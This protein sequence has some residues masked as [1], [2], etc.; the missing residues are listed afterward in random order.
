MVD[1]RQCLEDNMYEILDLIHDFVLVIDHNGNLLYTNSAYERIIGLTREYVRENILGRHINT[2]IYDRQLQ[3][4]ILSGGKLQNFRYVI[5]KAGIEVAGSVLPIY[6]DGCFRGAVV[7][8]SMTQIGE[9]FESLVESRARYRKDQIRFKPKDMLPECFQKL[10]GNNITFVKTLV[11]ASAAAATNSTILLEGESGVGKELLARAIHEASARRD[12]PFITINCAAIPESLL[13]S[14]LFGYETGAFTGASRKGKPGRFELASGGTLF[15]DEV[16]DLSLTMQAKILRALQFH[17]IERVGGT[18]KI[19]VDVR[20]ISATNKNLTQLT[21]KG[22]FREDLYYRLNVIPITLPPLAE[23]K[24]DIYLLAD[25]FLTGLCREYRYG[26]MRFA[27]DVIM[28]FHA[29]HW[30]GNVRE[31]SNVIEH[32]FV[33]AASESGSLITARHL[34][35]ALLQGGTKEREAG[36]E[37]CAR[38]EA[39]DGYVKISVAGRQMKELIEELEIKVMEKALEF[40]SNRS[41]LIRKLGFNRSTFYKKAKKYKII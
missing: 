40:C 26:S 5:E 28:I 4:K 37:E 39:E 3:E 15:L 38:H 10:V 16:G 21:R 31:L 1:L 24:D 18:R 11:K 27:S 22:F 36:E 9:L 2:M 41:D 20:I 25:H 14:E 32:S 6:R 23:R 35:P 30:P 13:E 8:V 33:L 29:Y 34:P 19:D 12:G 7:V 17:Q